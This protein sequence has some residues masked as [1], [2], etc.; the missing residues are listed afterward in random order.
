MNEERRNKGCKR[1]KRQRILALCAAVLCCAVLLAGCGGGAVSM[2]EMDP[3]GISKG[4]VIG[5]S[6][7][8]QLQ[9]LSEGKDYD[10]EDFVYEDEFADQSY[11]T[12]KIVNGPDV[13]YM[14]MKGENVSGVEYDM[15]YQQD[16]IDRAGYWVDFGDS[17]PEFI[18]GETKKVYNSLKKIYG[19]EGDCVIYFSDAENIE[20]LDSDFAEIEKNIKAKTPGMYQMSW[21]KDGLRVNFTITFFPEMFHSGGGLWFTPEVWQ[22]GSL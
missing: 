21:L 15:P 14:G 20:F 4:G 11:S 16:K 9:G 18:A 19:E 8:A 5:G 12:Y 1:G 7:A 17:S 2:E 22:G 10:K 13:V 3:R 6:L